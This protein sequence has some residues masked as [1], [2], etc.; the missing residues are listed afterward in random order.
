MSLPEGAIGMV[1]GR[2]W[3]PRIPEKVSSAIPRIPTLPWEVDKSQSSDPEPLSPFA[4]DSETNYTTARGG[5]LAPMFRVIG[6]NGEAAGACV[7][8]RRGTAVATRRS[9]KKGKKASIFSVN[10]A[11]VLN[12]V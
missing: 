10:N 4:I 3:A 6:G 8:S 12:L 9:V 1:W 7:G 11:L 2:L 5:S